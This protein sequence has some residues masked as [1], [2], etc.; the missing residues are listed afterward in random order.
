MIAIV[1][2]VKFLPPPCVEDLVFSLPFEV[3]ENVMVGY[4]VFWNI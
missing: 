1:F 2:Y 3:H 4:E